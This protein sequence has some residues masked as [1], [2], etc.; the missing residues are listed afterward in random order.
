MRAREV[1]I[2]LLGK[3]VWDIQQRKDKLWVEVIHDKYIKEDK[4]L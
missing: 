3:L 1:N 4:F 2:A